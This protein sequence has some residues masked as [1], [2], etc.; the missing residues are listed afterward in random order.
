M[1]IKLNTFVQIHTYGGKE[2]VHEEIISFPWQYDD[3]IA[4]V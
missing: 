2:H 4:H 1:Y 3:R